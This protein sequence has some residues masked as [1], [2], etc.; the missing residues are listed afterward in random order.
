MPR[1]SDL[2]SRDSFILNWAHHLCSKA[3]TIEGKLKG[4]RKGEK[5]P[6]I[7]N[8]T[9]NTLLGMTEVTSFADFVFLHEVLFIQ[10]LL[11]GRGP[12]KEG[13]SCWCVKASKISFSQCYLKHLKLSKL[14]ERWSRTS[15]IF[16]FTE[17]QRHVNILFSLHPVAFK[18]HIYV[19][20]L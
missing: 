2:E 19:Y 14:K 16:H 9:H 1:G 15:S 20:N 6:Y 7:T 8:I 4:L 18:V 12:G 10:S 3:F 11:V 13:I 17:L 5:N